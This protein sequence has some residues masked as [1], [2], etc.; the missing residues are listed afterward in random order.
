MRICYICPWRIGDDG[1]SRKVISQV[2]ALSRFGQVDVVS[3]PAPHVFCHSVRVW[4]IWNL[5]EQLRFLLVSIRSVPNSAVVYYRYVPS[6]FLLNLF[7]ALLPPKHALVVENNT[8]NASELMVARRS[9][10][11]VIN[12]LTEGLVY[13]R[14]VRVVALSRD[15]LGYVELVSRGKAQCVQITNAYD[16]DWVSSC[17]HALM[18]EWKSKLSDYSSSHRLAVF[19]GYPQVWHGLDRVLQLLSRNSGWAL[20]V[21]GPGFRTAYGE[22]AGR[23]GVGDRVAFVGEV[24]GPDLGCIYR[25][26][27]LGFSGFG[28]DRIG[29]YESTSLKVREYIHHDLPVLIGCYD[30][31]IQYCDRVCTVDP[32]DS[33][34][35]LD[36]VC[37]N[38]KSRPVRPKLQLT[39]AY[40]MA[41][42][43][44]SL[45][46]P[47]FVGTCRG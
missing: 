45:N 11:R 29:M 40:Q 39:W 8:K 30:Q 12:W 41:Q 37:D 20:V 19:V 44:E 47:G 32:Q 23:L 2:K 35:S 36:S 13:R 24:G 18:A 33:S 25:L 6:H 4:V 38:L 46:L 31:A 3:F 14:A 22:L 16:P 10:A 7:V 43:A 9:A 42:V 1:V 15:L 27:D 26:C 21:V 34:L 17:D 28:L 5:W